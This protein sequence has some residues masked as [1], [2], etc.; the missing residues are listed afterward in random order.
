MVWAT[1]RSTTGRVKAG[2]RRGG[3]GVEGTLTVRAA[4]RADAAPIAAIHVA[5]FRTTYETLLPPS[6]RASLDPG[7]RAEVWRGRIGAG[8]GEVVVAITDGRIVGFCWFG[9]TTDDDDPPDRVGQVRSIHVA[10]EAVGRGYGK[11]LLQAA[12]DAL[13]ASGRAEVTLWVV[14]SN[15]RATA[16]YRRGGWR[17]DGSTRREHLGLPGEDAPLVDV[18]RMRLEQGVCAQART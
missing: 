3:V 2:A 7:A 10:P 17:E 8:D 11:A 12:T 13:V 1:L 5:S 4:T 14:A 15:D 6:I 16:I 9:P 18:I